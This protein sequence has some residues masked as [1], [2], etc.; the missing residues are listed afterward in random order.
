MRVAYGAV[1]PG[2][3][4]LG[5]GQ[6]LRQVFANVMKN[7]LESTDAAA[8][9]DGWT[10]DLIARDGRAVVEVRDNGV[11]IAP[12]Q[13][14]KIFLPF[15]TTKPVGHRARHVDRQ[16]DHGPARRRG[17]DRQPPGR[18]RAVRL[19]IPRAWPRPRHGCRR[20]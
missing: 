14:D 8:G 13:R 19:V 1:D 12:E 3:M 2:A 5:D 15:F 18:G 7:A 17:R 4:V 16:E 6:K 10:C 20:R 11:G 9:G